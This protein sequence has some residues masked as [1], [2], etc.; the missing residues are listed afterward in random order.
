VQQFFYD[1]QIRRFLLQFARI[2]S[3][4]QVEYGKTEPGGE[5]TLLRLP[6]RYGDASRNAQTIIQQNSSNKMPS[7][8]LMTFYI[9]GMQYDRS[10]IQEPYYVDKQQVRQ[11]TYD[12]ETDSYDTS[13]GNAFTIER[14]MPVPY[15]MTINADLWTSNTHQKF[16]LFEQIA[17]LFNPSLELQSTD[18]FLD[19]TSLS[20]AELSNVNWSSRSIPTG[21]DDSI[22]VMTMSFALPIW[23]SSPAKVKKLGIVERVVA[24]IHD[25]NGDLNDSITDNDLLM[26]TRLKVTP[27]AYQVLLIGNKLQIVENAT[28]VQPSNTSLT[29]TT[30]LTSS[31]LSW[32][33]VINMYGQM[34]PGISQL[35]LDGDWSDNSEIVGTITIDPTDPRFLLFS[36]DSDTI[37]SNTLGTVDA[38][39]DPLI[40]GPGAGLADAVQ[41][42][43]YLLVNDIGDASNTSPSTSWGDIVAKT[44]DIIEFNDG[45]WGISFNASQVTSVQFMTNSAT[46]VQYKWTGTSWMKSYEGLYK[47]GEWA[48]VL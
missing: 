2:F 14:L 37:P 4:F 45:A 31:H 15:N 25:S 8:P 44:N 3:N 24:S 41:G 16:Q 47:G 39:I 18:N 7:T 30:E 36:I 5:P 29:P 42:Q 22:D 19:W 34:R 10:R 21:V 38:I 26:G 1:D 20:V 12:E 28:A 46:S 6:V 27:Y 13:Q 40:S 48:L 43:R 35:R 33:T 32:N 17:T 23:I 9:T 11:R